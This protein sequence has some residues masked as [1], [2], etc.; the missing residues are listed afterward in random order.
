MY[1]ETEAYIE[2]R[3]IWPDSGRH[4][5]AQYD[6]TSVVVYQAYR[7]DIGRFAA[8]HGYFGGDFRYTRMSWIKPN[9]LWMMYRCG[10]ATKSD[11]ET[12]LAVTLTRTAFDEI[13]Q[14]AVHSS[15]VEA[16]YGNRDVWQ[17]AVRSSGVRLQWDPDH[18][19]NGG[20]LPRRAIQLGLQGEFLKKYG[21]DWIVRIEDITDFV[22]EQR[23]HLGHL[24]DLKTPRERV[25]PVQDEATARRLGCTN[26]T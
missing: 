5:L 25:Y 24:N 17:K 14:A 8:E 22:T 6:A 12:V 10:W 2:Q 16:I 13:L 26:S 23:S 7:P 15:Y 21:R 18:A 4:I 3:E 20:R 9:F 11:Q 19:P 1:L